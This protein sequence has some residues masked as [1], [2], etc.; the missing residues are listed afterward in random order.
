VFYGLL[1]VAM[2]RVHEWS[3]QGRPVGVALDRCVP[4]A[5]LICLALPIFVPRLQTLNT[6][7]QLVTWC[8]PDPDHTSRQAIQDSLARSAGQ[9][10]LIVRYSPDHSP[11]DEWVSND[12]DIDNSKVIWARDM[13]SQN[14]EL[15]RYFRTRKVWMVEPDNSPPHLFLTSTAQSEPMEAGGR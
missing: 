3:P 15:I 11:R 12:A 2:K 10:L 8:S 13:G 9:Y 6:I 4:M 1:V 7:P 5:V 14:Q